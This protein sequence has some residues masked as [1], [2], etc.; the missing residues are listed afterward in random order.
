MILTGTEKVE[1][2]VMRPSSTL[3]EVMMNNLTIYC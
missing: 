1:Q 2:L 3:R